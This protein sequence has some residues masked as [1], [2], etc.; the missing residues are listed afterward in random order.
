MGGYCQIYRRP[1]FT[2]SAL[3]SRCVALR[4]CPSIFCVYAS[5]A[6]QQRYGQ[7]YIYMD[8]FCIFYIYNK[9]YPYIYGRTQKWNLLFYG[10][11]SDGDFC[12]EMCKNWSKLPAYLAP[13]V[14]R[15]EYMVTM[16]CAV[17]LRTGHSHVL[18]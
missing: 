6:G 7:R 12:R 16:S 10:Q 3:F 8:I 18:N 11:K 17:T 5:R 9:F 1:T 15:G 4:L 13:V 14:T 2:A